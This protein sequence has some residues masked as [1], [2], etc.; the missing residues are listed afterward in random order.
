M[1]KEQ[2]NR[3]RRAQRQMLRMILSA[4]RRR[5][6][7]PQPDHALQSQDGQTDE[8]SS[9]TTESPDVCINDDELEPWVDWI[10]RSTHEAEL[11]LRRLHIDDWVTIQRRRKW[12]CASRVAR[13]EQ[14]WSHKVLN[15]EPSQHTRQHH[16]GHLHI[17]CQPQRRQARPKTRWSDD[18][19]NLVGENW[20]HQAQS[21][22]WS[23]WKDLYMKA[24][25]D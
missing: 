20:V 5:V 6:T 14:T 1:T 24:T 25:D 16:I 10:R 15:W 9:Q 12:E 17:H 11:Q 22:T 21:R 2:R 13:D 7:T 23:Q 19:S 3:I 8:H 4:P 18:F